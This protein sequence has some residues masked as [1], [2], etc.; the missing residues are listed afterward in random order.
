MHQYRGLSFCSA[1]ILFMAWITSVASDD[2]L[3]STQ[4]DDIQNSTRA[5]DELFNTTQ[6]DD[7]LNSANST[8][9][10]NATKVRVSNNT[11]Y[12]LSLP[13]ILQQLTILLLRS[14]HSPVCPVD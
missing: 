7:R 11:G 6:V 3:N 1:G 12:F 5:S 4:A 13:P 8:E 10:G 14:V 2:L 9:A